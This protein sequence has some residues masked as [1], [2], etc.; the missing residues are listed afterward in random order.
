VHFFPRA[1][2]FFLFFFC[3]NPTIFIQSSLEVLQFDDFKK[4]IGKGVFCEGTFLIF[5]GQIIYVG[6]L[7]V[8]ELKCGKPA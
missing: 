5:I 3:I 8:S 1:F 4:I 2:P 7:Y 6:R